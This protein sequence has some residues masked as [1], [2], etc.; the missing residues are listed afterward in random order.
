M[1]KRLKIVAAYADGWNYGLSTYSEYV[2]KR[3]NYFHDDNKISASRNYD[4]IVK[5]WYGI[6]LLGIDG[7]E[8]RSGGE[9]GYIL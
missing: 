3:E 2:E 5:A 6:L 8:L 1:V 4:D 9:S 7:N